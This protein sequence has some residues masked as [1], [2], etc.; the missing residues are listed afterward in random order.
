MDRDLQS[1]MPRAR[2]AQHLTVLRYFH[3]VAKT[4]SIREAG[5]NLNVA[6]SAISR[7]I[8]KLEAEVGEVLFERL[9]RG[10]KLTAA[11]EIYSEYVVDSLLALRRLGSEIQQ[12]RDLKLG[13]VKIAA[14]E[15]MVGSFLSPLVSSFR[16]EFP[17][18][19]F[20][21]LVASAADV[22]TQLLAGTA[23]IG[24]AFNAPAQEKIEY[25]LRIKDPVMAIMAPDFELSDIERFDLKGIAQ[26]PVAIPV[27]TFGIRNLLDQA[28]REAK[29]PINPTLETNSIEALRAFA[30][31]G[32]G[33]SLLHTYAV[34]KELESGELIARPIA[35]TALTGGTID[36]CILSERLLPV[37]A[38]EF[39]GFAEERLTQVH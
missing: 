32:D 5:D 34:K 2:D 27:S 15:G 4:G 29:I 14:I 36:L 13:T 20:Q 22:T 26:S 38:K 19:N 16:Q 17:D 11:G 30:K 37:A 3:E 39:L 10:M 12:L 35:S 7:Q 8:S 18:I 6:S 23:D 1:L 21:L 33:I 31:N 9:P 25:R 28:C 24:L